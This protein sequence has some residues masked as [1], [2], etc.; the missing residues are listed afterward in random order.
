VVDG[1]CVTRV[2]CGGLRLRHCFRVIR[3]GGGVLLVPF[4]ALFFFRLDNIARKAPV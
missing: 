3:I 4:L 1:R 2:F